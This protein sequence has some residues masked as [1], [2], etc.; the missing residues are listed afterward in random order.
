M[1]NN[2]TNIFRWDE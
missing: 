2:E 1:G